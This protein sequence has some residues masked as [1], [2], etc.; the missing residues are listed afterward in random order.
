[1]QF[2]YFFY[3]RRR[4]LRAQLEQTGYI[5]WFVVCL[6]LWIY[7]SRPQS[8]THTH[9]KTDMHVPASARADV[10]GSNARPIEMF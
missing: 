7:D 2:F 1:M 9:I 3:V 4:L 8:Q 10:A 6:A 5:T